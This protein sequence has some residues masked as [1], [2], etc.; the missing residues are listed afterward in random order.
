MNKIILSGVFCI[1]FV[2]LLANP[3]PLSL[4][5]EDV[6]LLILPFLLCLFCLSVSQPIVIAKTQY[7]LCAAILFYCLYLILS[8][9]VGLLHDVPFLNILRGIGPYINFIPL[10]A[11]GFVPPQRLNPW[12][13]AFILMMIGSFQACFQLYLYFSHSV[14]LVNTQDVLRGRITLF[15][16]RT[17]LP[18]VLAAAIL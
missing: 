1:L 6:I 3:A 5:I 16:P 4:E 18:L 2:A 9:L 8:I 10:L 15:N 11:I 14:H 7:Q 13:I 12:R 17:T